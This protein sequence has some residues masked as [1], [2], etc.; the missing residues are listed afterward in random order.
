[1][2]YEV[3]I[4]PGSGAY[5]FS[6]TVP[7]LP[8]CYAVGKTLEEAM[9]NLKEA[10]VIWVKGEREAGRPIPPPSDLSALKK[11]EEYAHQTW[12]EINI[13]KEKF[14]FRSASDSCDVLSLIE[15]F[16]S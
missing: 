12:T 6:L 13:D 16:Q 3:A 8:G 1:M 14:L 7:D 2:K 5:A 11:H 9:R 10:S 4:E 15:P